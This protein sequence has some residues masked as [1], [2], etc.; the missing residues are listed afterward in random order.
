VL[1]DLEA[2]TETLREQFVKSLTAKLN[3]AGVDHETPF[4]LAL[5]GDAVIVA[6]DHPDKEKIEAVLAENPVL[7]DAFKDIKVQSEV[8]RNVR[9]NKNVMA[10]RNAMATYTNLFQD[11]A[12]DLFSL[13]VKAF[14]SAVYFGR[15]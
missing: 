12:D 5:E 13:S 2:R 4:N 10:M 3:E 7:G 1:D 9:A 14:S 6:N 15:R 8:A 11:D